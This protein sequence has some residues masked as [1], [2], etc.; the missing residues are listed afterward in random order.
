MTGDWV[1]QLC[2]ADDVAHAE[3]DI[4]SLFGSHE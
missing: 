4:W 3:E 2:D 1:P